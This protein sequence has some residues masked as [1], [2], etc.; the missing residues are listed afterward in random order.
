MIFRTLIFSFPKYKSSIPL[1]PF[2]RPTLQVL[3]FEFL[4]IPAPPLAAF[5]RQGSETSPQQPL[6]PSQRLIFAG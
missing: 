2:R 1:K 5:D 3:A 6:R 4:S